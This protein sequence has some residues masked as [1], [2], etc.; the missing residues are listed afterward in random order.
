MIKARKAPGSHLL[1]NQTPLSY[2]SH[3]LLITQVAR[4]RHVSNYFCA[5]AQFPGDL[6][7]NCLQYR[8]FPSHTREIPDSAENGLQSW[9]NPF[10]IFLTLFQSCS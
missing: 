9:I 8:L 10:L 3:I 1:V 2:L 7:I 5:T 6:Y 4:N